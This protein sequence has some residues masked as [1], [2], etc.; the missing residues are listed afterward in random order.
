MPV[1]LPPPDDAEVIEATK[2]SGIVND[3]DT[4]IKSTS[5]RDSSNGNSIDFNMCTNGNDISDDNKC[6]YYPV[7]IY[8]MIGGVMCVFNEKE[9]NERIQKRNV[10][11]ITSNNN[12][13]KSHHDDDDCCQKNH[14]NLLYQYIDMTIEIITMTII[15]IT[16]TMQYKV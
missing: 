7:L 1:F 9:R 4:H 2:V 6:K 10:S 8:E 3:S 12:S 14:H 5:Q 15:S 16:N 13:D 11:N